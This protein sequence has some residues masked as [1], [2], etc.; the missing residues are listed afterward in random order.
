VPRPAKTKRQR[1]AD[2]GIGRQIEQIR[3]ARKIGVREFAESVGI[4]CAR[5]Y[6]YECG[7]SSLPVYLLAPMAQTLRIEV[8]ELIQILSKIQ[9]FEKESLTPLF[10]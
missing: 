10:E 3:R 6:N 8:V 4:S 9:D 7:K 2:V 1:D 5:L